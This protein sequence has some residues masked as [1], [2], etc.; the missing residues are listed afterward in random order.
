[1]DDVFR[2]QIPSDV[3]GRAKAIAFENINIK[4]ATPIGHGAG[5]GHS[6]VDVLFAVGVDPTNDM[7]GDADDIFAPG[8]QIKKVKLGGDV[9]GSGA[10]R[11]VDNVDIVKFGFAADS[12]AGR[13]TIGRDRAKDGT[14]PDLTAHFIGNAMSRD[15]MNL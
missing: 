10:A 1:M 12:L 3:R 2:G 11:S 8:G 4:G 6:M 5:D 14:D 7:L 13:W 15:N 9:F